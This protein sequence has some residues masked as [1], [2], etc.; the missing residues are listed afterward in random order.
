MS[1]TNIAFT[2]DYSTTSTLDYIP[3]SKGSYT[4]QVYVKDQ[5]STADYED[6]KTSSFS[7][8]ESPLINSLTANKAQYL[9]G[10][11]VSLNTTATSGTGSYLYKYVI[12]LGGVTLSTVEYSSKANLLYTVNNAGN[13]TITVYMKDALSSKDYD[14]MKVLTIPVYNKPTM[15]Y[16]ST[17][18]FIL[19][20]NTVNFTITEVNGSGNAQYRFVAMRGSTTVLDSG[21]LTSNTFSFK[22]ST[23]GAY[24]VIGYLKDSI[25]EK[26]FDVQSTLN[27][28]VYN[29]QLTTVNINGYFYEGKKLTLNASSTGA[30]PPGLSYRYEVYNNGSKVA[31]NTFSTLSTFSFTPTVSGTYTVKV[32]GKDGLSKNV[33]DSM[34]QFNIIVNSKPLYIATLPL[35]YGMTNNDVVSLQSALIKLGYSVSSATG[36]FGSQT[37]NAVSSFQTSAGIPASGTVGT[38]TYV[39]LNDALIAKAGIKN[40]TF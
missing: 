5:S 9:M 7:V 2:R 8:Y 15:T 14:D 40:L 3:N 25:S 30:S 1:G 37:S 39:A 24:Q 6:T 23:A 33:Y 22:P 17:Q 38:W 10:Q 28:N 31:S 4:V 34:K 29:P 20:G 26:A 19:I 13:Y 18:N 27:L 35:S 12:S 16:T 21:Y 36:Y 11:T 32:Y